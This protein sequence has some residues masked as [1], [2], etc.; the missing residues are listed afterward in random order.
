MR[1]FNEDYVV[2]D[3]ETGGFVGTPGGYPVEIGILRYKDGEA[4]V[5]SFLVDQTQN[6]E[7]EMSP[8]AVKAHGITEDMIQR[9]GVKPEEAA[10]RLH[11]ALSGDLPIWAHMGLAFDF[12]ILE[13]QNIKYGLEPIDTSRYRDSAGIYKAVTLGEPISADSLTEDCLNALD[14]RWRGFFFNLGYL[15]C[16][17]N[18]GVRLYDDSGDPVGK[19]N[20]KSASA[21]IIDQRLGLSPLQEAK[22]KGYGLHRAAF[23]CVVTHGLI[24][25]MRSEW[26]SIFCEDSVL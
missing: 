21:Y 26:S 25:W 6:P 16:T 19:D 4:K 20:V 13:Q 10:S 3:Y 14:V 1:V 23:D 5:T 24:Q 12:P 15:T 2:F 8:G 9:H 11:T 18:I 17:K 22:V 7:F